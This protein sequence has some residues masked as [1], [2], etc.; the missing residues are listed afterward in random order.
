MRDLFG[1]ALRAAARA[2]LHVDLTEAESRQ[3][4][5]FGKLETALRRLSERLSVSVAIPGMQLDRRGQVSIAAYELASAASGGSLE[6][7]EIVQRIVQSQPE[8]AATMRRVTDKASDAEKLLDESRT[9]S[10]AQRTFIRR[11][12]RLRRSQI[13]RMRAAI[14]DATALDQAI[15]KLDEIYS[16]AVSEA[17]RL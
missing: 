15:D 2:R 7:S 14:L 9:S 17:L 6:R 11:A 4:A 3:L 10:P 8:C 16:R 12:D 5:A 13:N 1:T